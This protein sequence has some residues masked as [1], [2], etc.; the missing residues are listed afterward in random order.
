MIIGCWN[1]RGLNG[2][3]TACGVKDFI[4]LNKLAI[5]GLLETKLN[6]SRINEVLN[7]RLR[8]WKVVTNFSVTPRGKMAIIWDSSKVDCTVI[9]ISE[10]CIHCGFTCKETQN[11]IWGS[12]VYGFYLVVD[13]RRLW[14]KLKEVRVPDTQPWFI[15]GDFNAYLSPEDKVGGII[16]SRYEIADYEECCNTLGIKDSPSCGLKY[17]WGKGDVKSK[18]D[19]VLINEGWQHNNLSC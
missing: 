18:L 16:P 10:Q 14:N 3:L 17:T 6:T 13:R 5:C 12:F 9:D 8:G 19:R 15:A 2:P 1:V 7:R 4:K 11:K